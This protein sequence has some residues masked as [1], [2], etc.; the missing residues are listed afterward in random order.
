MEVDSG[1]YDMAMLLALEAL[2]RV[3]AGIS[4]RI[5][6]ARATNTVNINDSNVSVILQFEEHIYV[7]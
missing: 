6:E 3:S 2:R 5:S 4:S 1:A 7:I